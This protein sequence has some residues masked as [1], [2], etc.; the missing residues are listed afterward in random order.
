MADEQGE[1]REQPSAK[2]L[3]DARERGQISRSRDLGMAVASLGATGVLVGLGPTMIARLLGAITAAFTRLAGT[4]TGELQ[5]GDISMLVVGGGSLLALVVGPVAVAAAG[6]SVLTTLAQGGL[7]FAPKALTLDWSRLS[8]AH[9]IK[10]LAFKQSGMDT[11][12]AL[13][14]V[15]VLGVLAWTVGSQL[16]ADSARLSWMA[17]AKAAGRG[18]SALTRLLWQSGFALAVAGGI[19]YGLQRWRLMS[20]LKMSRQEIKDE[21]RSNEGRPEVKARV[22]RIQRDMARRRMLHATRTA[23]VVI[24]NP[25]HFAVALEYRRDRGAAPIVVAKGQDLVAA[26]IR[27][28]AREH[29]VPIIENPPLARALH[30]GAEVGDAIPADLFAAV[31]EVL[32]YLIRI[33]Q[34]ML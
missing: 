23:T 18:W 27:E 1:K 12:K 13:L 5:P 22:R 25:T 26:R 14:A 7:N 2:R 31:A 34:L 20:T 11:V 8:F 33:K 29:S 6:A 28:I 4:P 3:K 17:P 24:T 15:S 9:G 10:R 30:K 32:A 16:F 19:D 21:L